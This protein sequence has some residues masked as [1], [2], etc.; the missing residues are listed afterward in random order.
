MYL[1]IIKNGWHFMKSKIYQERIQEVNSDIFGYA[2][3]G[4]EHTC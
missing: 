4:K 3:G 2:L 1:S